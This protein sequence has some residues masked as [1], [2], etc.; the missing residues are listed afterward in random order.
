[1]MFIMARSILKCNTLLC[2]GAHMS[3]RK[4]QQLQ[5]EERVTIASMKQQ[6]VSVRAMARTLGR[7]ASS[8]SRELARNTCPVRH[9]GWGA[10]L[11]SMV[12]KCELLINVVIRNKPKALSGLSQ[13]ACSR[14]SRSCVGTHGSNDCRRKGRT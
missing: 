11:G 7:P 8:V 5:P 14:L 9:G 6:G 4:Y 3:S 12:S 13:K 1:M 10:R 2:Q